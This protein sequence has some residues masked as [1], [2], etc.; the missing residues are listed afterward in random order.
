[1]RPFAGAILTSCLTTILVVSAF[2]ANRGT[3][4]RCK[5]EPV[6]VSGT[7]DADR[8]DGTPGRDVIRA[9]AGDDRIEA[10]GGRDLVCAGR[11]KDRVFAGPGADQMMGGR[12]KDPIAGEAGPDRLAGG[13]GSD[14]LSGNVGDDNVIGGRASDLMFGDRGRDR[15][16]G[17][18]PR[19]GRGRGDFADGTCERRSGARKLQADI[20]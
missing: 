17:R 19:E 13:R 15:C 8:L 18:T 5:G 10:G 20:A 3:E 6:T 2:G 12:G 11:G 14:V 9:G 1:M 16:A 7:A 4:L